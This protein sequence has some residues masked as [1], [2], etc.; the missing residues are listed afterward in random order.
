MFFFNFL[1]KTQTIQFKCLIFFSV[2]CK[3]GFF[4]NFDLNLSFNYI[5]VVCMVYIGLVLIQ[6][7]FTVILK[8]W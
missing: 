7:I 2:N 3:D 1:I 4:L 8:F 6:A 5:F